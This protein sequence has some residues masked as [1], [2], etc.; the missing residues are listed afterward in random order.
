MATTRTF[1]SIS[2]GVGDKDLIDF[3]E[4]L[5][6]GERSAAIRRLMRQGMKV[7]GGTAPGAAEPGAGLE[8]A[9][10]GSQ[11]VGAESSGGVIQAAT[12]K[13]T[14]GGAGDT[15]APPLASTQAPAPEPAKTSG[16]AATP[17]LTNAERMFGGQFDN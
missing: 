8:T 10:V 15:S 9:H 11:P 13:Q 7:G 5:N 12:Q 2:L 17:E 4:N 16:P 3:L 1:F 14:D 6:P